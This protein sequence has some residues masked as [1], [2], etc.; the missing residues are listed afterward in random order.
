MHRQQNIQFVNYDLCVIFFMA[1]SEFERKRE[2][3]PRKNEMKE[4]HTYRAWER[5]DVATKLLS[6]DMKDL[7]NRETMFKR[8]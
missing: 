1:W 6:D 3:L 2:E 7:V 5:W 8:I 4:A